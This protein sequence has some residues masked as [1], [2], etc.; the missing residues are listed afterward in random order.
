[1]YIKSKLQNIAIKKRPKNNQNSTF[2]MLKYGKFYLK[3]ILFLQ[4]YCNTNRNKH[5]EL[6]FKINLKINFYIPLALVTRCY[7]RNFLK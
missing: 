2:N 7:S 6:A 1:M 5:S 3:I 4:L